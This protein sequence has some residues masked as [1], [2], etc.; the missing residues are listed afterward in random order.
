MQTRVK[1]VLQI[2][3]DRFDLAAFKRS[4]ELASEGQELRQAA[5]MSEAREILKS[6]RPDLILVDLG[7]PDSIDPVVEIRAVMPPACALVVLTGADPEDARDLAHGAPVARKS[8]S[9]NSHMRGGALLGLAARISNN[10]IPASP[11]KPTQSPP[12]SSGPV[13]LTGQ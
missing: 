9:P 10:Q 7:L 2:D 11:G 12:S 3:D 1:K 5:S 8:A 6:F 4:F 13:I